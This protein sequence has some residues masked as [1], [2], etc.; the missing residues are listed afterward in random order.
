M[1]SFLIWLLFVFCCSFKNLSFTVIALIIIRLLL[2]KEI[3]NVEGIGQGK[4]WNTNIL[5]F[6]NKYMYFQK[7]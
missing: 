2:I 7:K 4:N 5:I 1:I 6:I 3:A